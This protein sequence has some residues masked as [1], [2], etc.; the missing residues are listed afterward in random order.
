[1]ACWVRHS[2]FAIFLKFV[3]AGCRKFGPAR[4]KRALPR[5]SKRSSWSL[6]STRH[7]AARRCSA[8]QF[9]APSS[10]SAQFTFCERHAPFEIVQRLEWPTLPLFKELFSVFLT[11]SVYDAK[12]ETHRVVID[13]CAMPIGLQHANRFH[14]YTVPLRVLHNRCR[15]VKTHRLIVQQAG[16]K[17]RCAMHFEIGAA[18]S[19]NREADRMRFGKAVKRKRRNRL[20]DIFDLV[21]RDAFAFHGGAEFHVHFRIRS[22]E[23]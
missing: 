10:A 15:S 17:F 6:S 16:V 12:S 11:Q 21:G 14:V 22:C 5:S 9:S 13:D 18:V 3:S 7:I 23:R 20:N 8:K 1:M 2:A 4:Q 19:Q